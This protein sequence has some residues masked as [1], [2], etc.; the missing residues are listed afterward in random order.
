MTKLDL[1]KPID[2][3]GR[4]VTHLVLREPNAREL[5]VHGE[6]YIQSCTAEG[7]IV[8]IEDGAAIAAYLDAI[9]VEP[10]NLPLDRVGLADGMRLKDA[11]LDFFGDARRAGLPTARSASSETSAGSTPQGSAAQA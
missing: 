7:Q 10:A 6:P 4:T 3:D 11:V 9:V 5:M 1:I 8:S 2:F